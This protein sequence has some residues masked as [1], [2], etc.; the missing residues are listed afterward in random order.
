MAHIVF[1]LI[2]P[3]NRTMVFLVFCVRKSGAIDGFWEAFLCRFSL[4][5][6][7][8]GVAYFG[9]ENARKCRVMGGKIVKKAAIVAPLEIT[10]EKDGRE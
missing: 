5:F 9:G 8:P 10:W 4:I 3:K 1:G 6:Q 7:A 2:N